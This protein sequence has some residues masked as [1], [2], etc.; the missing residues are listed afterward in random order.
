M[1]EMLYITK[2]ISD[3]NKQEIYVFISL[4]DFKKYAFTKKNNSFIPY[5]DKYFLDI[6][7]NVEKVMYH[8]ELEESPKENDNKKTKK[9]LS[10]KEKVQKVLAGLGIAVTLVSVEPALVEAVSYS[11]KRVNSFSYSTL[12][13]EK[14][15]NDEFMEQF[16]I[17]INKNQDYKERERK[18]IIEG[19]AKYI[20]DWGYLLEE[21]DKEYIL[22]MA[23]NVNINRGTWL[24]RWAIGSY[25]SGNI[26]ITNQVNDVPCVSHESAH[27]FSDRGLI[28]GSKNWFGLG[29]AFNEGINTSITD[30]YIIGDIAYPAQRYDTMKL[31]L[32]AEDEDIIIAYQK[33]GPEYF[34]KKVAERNK[35]INYTD[36]LR[37]LSM[38]DLELFLNYYKII[39]DYKLPV[40]FFKEKDELYNKMF[41]AKYGYDFS[42]SVDGQLDKI[43]NANFLDAEITGSKSDGFKSQLYSIPKNLLASK[44]SD[45]DY[46]KYIVGEN[47][48]FKYSEALNFLVSVSEVE[49]YNSW[50]EFCS[51]FAEK[52]SSDEEEFNKVKS[53][54]T[55]ELCDDNFDYYMGY[56]LDKVSKTNYSSEFTTCYIRE[57]YNILKKDIEN[58]EKFSEKKSVENFDEKFNKKIQQFL[59]QNNMQDVLNLYYNS[60]I[61]FVEFDSDCLHNCILPE[62]YM[63]NHKSDNYVLLDNGLLILKT[64][65]NEDIWSAKYG[66]E[67]NIYLEEVH[68]E[69]SIEMVNGYFASSNG[70]YYYTNLYSYSLGG[71]EIEKEKINI[72]VYSVVKTEELQKQR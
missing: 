39:E 46:S 17:A 25:G 61:K 56:A 26:N 13:D 24:P 21:A 14:T 38:M 51:A 18:V 33:E 44:A 49:K 59:I 63:M 6:L 11:L 2:V 55:Q 69:Q 3:V 52:Y 10:V 50:D 42:E 1:K 48:D 16:T 5:N 41:K 37:Y 12:I 19:Y 36:V 40:E 15:S 27:A 7:N 64:S 8:Q 47:Y 68:D 54:F 4:E 22:H 65:E 31:S 62:E 70:K 71:E 57:L 34:C 66:E 32:L 9:N 28:A 30:K 23:E 58:K 60:D 53:V 29:R 67:E 72:Y 43:Y 35:N 45:F 20:D